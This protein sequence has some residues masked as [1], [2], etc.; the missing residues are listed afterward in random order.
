MIVKNVK[1]VEEG[2]RDGLQNI[3]QYVP[4]HVKVELIHM[5]QCAGLKNIEVTSFVNKEWVPQFADNNEV[6]YAINKQ[7]DIKYG[8]LTPNLRGYRDALV[9]KPD[10]ISV[11]TAA[12]ETFNQKNINCSIE[13]SIERFRPVIESAKKDGIL[14]R[15][16][17]SCVA[18]CPYEGDID[19]KQVGYV[20]KLMKDI[21]V[22][23]LIV[24]D[25]I[26]TGTPNKIKEVLEQTLLH[27]SVD[28]ITGHYHDTYGQALANIYASLEMGVWHYDAAVAGLGGCPYAKGATG[29]VSTEDVVFMLHNMG[30]DTGINLDLLIDAG[31]YITKFLGIRNESKVAAALLAKRN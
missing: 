1:I 11:F 5:L 28:D 12:S 3:K 22:D 2:S 8:V 16:A 29:N 27:Y 7:S 9:H 17:I 23:N 18:G 25:T 26:G 31:E 20:V 24:A 6:M 14:V 13:E 30:I 21:G 10:F 4:T 15:G 19:P